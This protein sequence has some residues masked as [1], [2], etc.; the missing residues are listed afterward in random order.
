M[1]VASFWLMVIIVMVEEIHRC[2]SWLR[3]T[4]VVY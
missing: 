4:V 1:E 2:D 3:F